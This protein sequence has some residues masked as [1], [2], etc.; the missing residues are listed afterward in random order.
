M[1]DEL[2]TLCGKISLLEGEKIGTKISKGEIEETK[3]KGKNC[4]IGRVWTGKRVNKKAFKSVLSRIWRTVRRVVFKEIL[5]NI[6]LFEFEIEADKRRVM[7]GRPWSFDRQILVLNEFDGS[8]SPS[9]M[10][11]QHSPFWVQVHDMPLFCMT[12]GVGKKIGESLGALEDVDVA[13]EGAGWGRCL[14]VRVSIDLT[15][16]LERGRVLELSGKS[17]WVSFKYEKLPIF[18]FNCG[19]IVHG[20]KGCPEA[21]PRRMSTEGEMKPWGV[22]LRA[23]EPQRNSKAEEFPTDS[24]DREFFGH[25][26]HRSPEKSEDSS[27]G[28]CS[29]TETRRTNQGESMQDGPTCVVRAK[30]AEIVLMEDEENNRGGNSKKTEGV[31]E[32][33]ITRGLNE[34]NILMDYSPKYFGTISGPVSMN[35]E[36]YSG[37]V[38]H[39]GFVD[40]TRRDNIGKVE[41][42]ENKNIRKDQNTPTWKKRV[43]LN[44]KVTQQQSLRPELVLGK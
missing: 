31:K 13:G 11:F 30:D 24:V 39:S 38:E 33:D 17:S 4:L 10:A 3:I 34:E 18:C 21:R 20:D 27:K 8:I 37:L 6:W 32:G 12:K 43:R 5:E 29:E 26:G 41:G 16:P 44:A 28:N 14:Q 25:G 7:E 9:L 15:K 19:R 23:E 2:E 22:L 40:V 35:M 36:P 1:A 42:A